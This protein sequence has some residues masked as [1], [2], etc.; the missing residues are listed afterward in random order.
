MDA[1]FENLHQILRNLYAEMLPLCGDMIGVAKGVAGLGA[2]F[3]IAAK[4]WQ[5]LARAEPVDVY[6]LLRPF[7]GGAVHHVLSHFCIGDSQYGAESGGQGLQQYPA[8]ADAQYREVQPATGET[9]I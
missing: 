1:E 8:R 4:V 5:A 2:L 3:F 6:P 9:G 7:C